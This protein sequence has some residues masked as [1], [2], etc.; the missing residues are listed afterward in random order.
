MDLDYFSELF[1]SLFIFECFLCSAGLQLLVAQFGSPF[2]N[3]KSIPNNHSERDWLFYDFAFLSTSVPFK[4]AAQGVAAV[5]SKKYAGL[6]KSSLILS[7]FFGAFLS[8]QGF[9]RKKASEMSGLNLFLNIFLSIFFPIFIQ[10]GNTGVFT[11]IGTRIPIAN[12]AYWHYSIQSII[13]YYYYY[14]EKY[15]II[16]S[17]GIWM[18]QSAT[19]ISLMLGLK[20]HLTM[21]DSEHDS[22]CI[23]TL[24]QRIRDLI[25]IALFM[26][27][28]FSIFPPRPKKNPNQRQ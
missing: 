27:S 7:W 18:K 10:L 5:G 1:F 21:L 9:Q 2:R 3:W 4:E 17:L 14:Y 11:L 6:L 23:L 28:S 15:S 8:F 26:Q 19:D 22:L 25:L 24:W 13:H 16:A 20:M 12:K